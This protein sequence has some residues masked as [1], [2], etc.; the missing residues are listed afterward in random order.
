M[1]TPKGDV[2]E[3]LLSIKNLERKPV[4]TAQALIPEETTMGCF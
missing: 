2:K 4:S 3:V 1:R